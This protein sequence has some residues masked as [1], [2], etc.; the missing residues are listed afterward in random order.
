[1]LLAIALL[2]NKLDT[3][4]AL[5]I[6]AS[7]VLSSGGCALSTASPTRADDGSDGGASVACTTF[8]NGAPQI[9]DRATIGTMPTGTGGMLVDGAYYATESKLYAGGSGAV[10]RTSR[11]AFILAGSMMVVHQT[12]AVVDTTATAVIDVDG[13]AL[14]LSFRCPATSLGET[15]ALTY[16]ATPTTITLFDAKKNRETTYTRQ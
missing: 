3:V 15:K 4:D 13:S 16:T 1:M 12:D 7:L 14:T 2:M 11:D 10:V 5:R 8:A 6:L 9:T